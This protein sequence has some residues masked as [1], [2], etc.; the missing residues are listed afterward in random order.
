[1]SLDD[2]A[3][4]QVIEQAT[5]ADCYALLNAVIHRLKATDSEQLHHVLA[6]SLSLSIC[7]QPDCPDRC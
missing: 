5:P 2:P 6:R 3:L 1:M 7:A 4:L